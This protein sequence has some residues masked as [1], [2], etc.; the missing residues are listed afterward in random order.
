MA[1]DAYMKCV[2]CEKKVNGGNEN[3]YYLEAAN[4]QNKAKNTAGILIIIKNP[5]KFT[6]LRLI[7]ISKSLKFLK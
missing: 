6:I 1:S 3:Q 5:S 2:D 4:M 7:S